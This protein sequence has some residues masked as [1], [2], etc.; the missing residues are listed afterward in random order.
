MRREV[1]RYGVQLKMD[2][3]DENAA[4]LTGGR[5]RTTPV[6]VESIGDLER[7][8]LHLRDASLRISSALP[9]QQ[10]P[11]RDL[12]WRIWKGGRTEYRACRSALSGVGVCAPLAAVRSV[13]G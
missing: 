4:C 8:W 7:A 3:S 1:E 5:R 11:V 13:R 2:D 9:V 10:Q 6:P 12:D